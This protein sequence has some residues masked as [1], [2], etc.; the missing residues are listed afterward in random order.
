MCLKS[1]PIKLST[2][3][4][5]WKNYQFIYF[6]FFVIFSGEGTSDY[7]EFQTVIDRQSQT[8]LNMF[9]GMSNY[10]AATSLAGVWKI[11]RGK[12]AFATSFFSSFLLNYQG[13]C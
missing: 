4:G 11:P 7:V 2:S 3:E 8:P 13:I 9:H 12:F 5:Q 1:K 6:I 10:G